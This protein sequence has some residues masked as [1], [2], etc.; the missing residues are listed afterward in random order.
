MR[1]S[2]IT[3]KRHESLLGVLFG[4]AVY[5]TSYT[6]SH[7]LPESE[8]HVSERGCCWTVGVSPADTPEFLLE[9]SFG[10]FYTC[11]YTLRSE[12]KCTRTF[13]QL[14]TLLSLI[15]W[16][17]EFGQKMCCLLHLWITIGVCHTLILAI[18]YTVFAFF[19]VWIWVCWEVSTHGVVSIISR[20][21]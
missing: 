12:H 16:H 20:K 7:P 18:I 5:R 21:C 1:E 11:S 15:Y 14:H 10:S 3:I 6:L 4:L 19:H 13:F 2:A 17:A 9:R 8:R